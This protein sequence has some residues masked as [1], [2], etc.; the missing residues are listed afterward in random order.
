MGEAIHLP[1]F[2]PF[3]VCFE[4]G[5]QPF[6]LSALA[7]RKFK[8]PFDTVLISLPEHFEDPLLG[9]AES[10]AVR[11]CEEGCRTYSTGGS[12][13]KSPAK[14]MLMPPKGRR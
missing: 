11:V 9:F 10:L 13:H 14:M 1:S 4:D 2:C 7:L 5:F 8:S 6:V 12:C 3:P